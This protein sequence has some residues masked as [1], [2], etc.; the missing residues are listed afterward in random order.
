MKWSIRAFQ[1]LDSDSRG[2]LYKDELLDHIKTSGT[3]TTHQLRELVSS[4]E[5]KTSKDKI[6]LEEFEEL[7][8][9]RNFI[10]AVLENNL[11]IP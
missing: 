11:I 9:G 1:A 3:I 8:K 5:E 6:Y 7:I 4:L 2:F 10:K